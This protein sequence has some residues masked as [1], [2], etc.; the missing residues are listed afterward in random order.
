MKLLLKQSSLQPRPL[1]GCSQEIRLL[2]SPAASVPGAGCPPSLAGWRQRQRGTGAGG[3]VRRRSQKETRLGAPHI[4]KRKTNS[5]GNPVNQKH[6]KANRTSAK[7]CCRLL[8]KSSSSFWHRFSFLSCAVCVPR[9][10]IGLAPGS[11]ELGM[12]ST[13]SSQVP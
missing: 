12:L 1:F 5:R 7:V 6:Q 4:F 2:L 3:V 11:P 13:L 9:Y 10:A 8:S